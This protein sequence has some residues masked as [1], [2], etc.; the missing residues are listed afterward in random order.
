MR[1]PTLDYTSLIS[2]AI[3]L[4]GVPIV[5]FAVR[6]LRA[7]V[8]RERPPLGPG[9]E[10]FFAHTGT[11]IVPRLPRFNPTTHD[12]NE[13]WVALSAEVSHRIPTRFIGSVQVPRHPGRAKQAKKTPRPGM[14]IKN[15]DRFLLSKWAVALPIAV[16]GAP[17]SGKTFEL[18]KLYCELGRRFRGEGDW[19]PILIFANEIASDQFQNLDPRRPLHDFLFRYL[20]TAGYSE[21]TLRLLDRKF[22]KSR[23]VFIFDALDEIP[24]KQEYTRAVEAISRI[25]I[26]SVEQRRWRFI[27]S[28][29]SEDY[30]LNLQMYELEIQPLS[31]EQID[32]FFRKKASAFG[33]SR[34]K[35][36]ERAWLRI[37]VGDMRWFEPFV[38][39]PYFLSTMLDTLGYSYHENKPVPLDLRG[40]FSDTINR[41]LAKPS[42]NQGLVDN[43]EDTLP[44][45]EG[46]ATSFESAC[47][48]LA[49]LLL[50][51]TLRQRNEA[52]FT[53][54][55]EADISSLLYYCSELKDRAPLFLLINRVVREEKGDPE[56]SKSLDL[57]L[58]LGSKITKE[59]LRFISDLKCRPAER[60][61]ILEALPLPEREPVSFASAMLRQRIDSVDVGLLAC[62]FVTLR[63]IRLGVEK[64]LLRYKTV[65]QW[66]IVGFRHRRLLEYFAAAYLDTTR[67]IVDEKLDNLWYKQTL[68]ILAGIQR[69]PEWLLTSIGKEDF[70]RLLLLAEVM[71]F[72]HPS[73][74]AQVAA[75]LQS[76]VTSLGEFAF[77]SS[78][79]W[80]RLLA[81]DALARLLEAHPKATPST[82][83]A[84]VTTLA[85]DAA[86]YHHCLRLLRVLEKEGFMSKYDYF[87]FLRRGFRNLMTIPS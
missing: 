64:R 49:V 19:L 17:G 74:A 87:L 29:R 81:L 25:L 27:L 43:N 72:L 32:R 26:P 35:F 6:K 34:L 52:V 50:E 73:S 82:L 51:K 47:G 28:C 63:L 61:S 5:L 84:K 21:E 68:L 41:E 55:S 45:G 1:G 13:F 2:L 22:D 46:L 71:Q 18:V 59:V 67:R 53:P 42:L 78:A 39:N 14:H 37:Q 38:S 40:L 15:L 57:P 75:R 16:T 44:R 7:K 76:T 9:Y 79:S 60:E 65:P 80:N 11:L 83:P 54:T 33:T 24:D 86:F 77:S 31:K 3:K 36:A 56:L 70:S 69:E 23:F 12:V 20:K 8:R 4:V 30:D 62:V 48:I 58:Y 10:E 66:S 85:G